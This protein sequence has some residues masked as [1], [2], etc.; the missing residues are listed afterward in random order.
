MNGAAAAAAAGDDDNDDGERGVFS[1]SGAT[2]FHSYQWSVRSFRH[3]YL[4]GLRF[5]RFIRFSS[6]LR[7]DAANPAAAAAEAAPAPPPLLPLLPLS[8]RGIVIRYSISYRSTR[9]PSFRGGS[10]RTDTS[11][12]DR[13]RRFGQLGAIGNCSSR[14]KASA[15][16]NRRTCRRPWNEA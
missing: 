3:P 4:L 15:S 13:L 2:T 14:I 8:L 1:W 12:T 16:T 6:L 10:H 5:S 9:P 7:S 11:L